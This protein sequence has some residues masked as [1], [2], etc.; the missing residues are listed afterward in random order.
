MPRLTDWRPRLAAYLAAVAR[1][2]FAYGHHDCALFAAGAVA[3]ITG[4]DLAAPWRGHYRTALGGLRALRKAGHDDHVAFVAAH[5]TPIHPAFAN[6][7]DLAEVPGEGGPALGLVQGEY[8]HVLRAEGL[9][10]VPLLTATRCF[11]VK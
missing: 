6:V 2:P 8:I 1:A 11:E 5:F 7:G 9:A 10:S 4:E 3:A